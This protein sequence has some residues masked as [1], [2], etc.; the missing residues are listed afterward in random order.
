M[1]T[2]FT[3]EIIDRARGCIMGAFIGDASG[4][5]LEFAK[6]INQ[7]TIDSAMK[8]Q[9]GGVFGMT[10]GQI[11]DDGEL[12]MCVL[13][14][15]AN[16]KEGYNPD[17]ICVEYGRWYNSSPFD[18]GNTTKNALKHAAPMKSNMSAQITKA[19]LDMAYSF[20][21]GSTMKLSPTAVYCSFLKDAD[22]VKRLVET[23]TRHMHS[24]Q[25]VIDCNIA[26]ALAIRDL[27][28][29]EPADKAYQTMREFAIESSISKWVEE[30]E[31]KELQPVHLMIGWVK[32][33]FQQS[34][35]HLAMKTPFATAI[36]EI[37]SQGGDSDTNACIAGMLLGARDG[38]SK[39]PQESIDAVLKCDTK[40]IPRP[41]FLRP[42]LYFEKNFNQMIENCKKL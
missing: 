41:E 18:I 31:R 33:A 9:G 30:L 4:A 17:L 6:T 42:G 13:Q 37:I 1:E 7:Q 25:N 2:A 19:A 35:L 26:F 29:G 5:P 12:S 24:N 38:Y 8:M 3:Q 16:C 21:N 34:F 20:S 22:Q 15:L 14:G 10:P 11:T 27:I 32:I 39:L 40:R 28:R 23:E 36:R